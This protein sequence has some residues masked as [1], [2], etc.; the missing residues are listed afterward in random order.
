MTATGA[1]APPVPV[2]AA[3]RLVKHFPV[4]GGW[5]RRSGAQVHAVCDVSFALATGQTLALV[6]ES[7]CGKSTTA[8]LSA[9]LLTPDAGSVRFR[10]SD[11][12]AADRTE[13]RRYRQATAIV[14][15][16]SYA[17]LDPR[18]TVGKSIAEPLRV[19]GVA[20]GSRAD[21]VAE[22]L[23]QVGLSPAEAGR[24]PHQLSGGQRQRV[25]IARALSLAPELVVLDEP[26][27]ALDVSLRAGVTD[28]LG[29]L[30]ERTGVAYL[31]VSHDVSVVRHVAHRV[32]VM[33]LGRLVETGRLPDV[34]D[35]PAHPYTRALL[36]AVPLPDPVHERQRRRIVL[37]GEVPSAVRPPSGCRFR[38]RCWKAQAV[39]AEQTPSLA[40]VRPGHQVACHF[41]EED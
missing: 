1:A 23:R 13:Q 27:S 36:S 5:S 34:F 38:T 26:V 20:A 4:R 18:L 11:L 40:D 17:S 21:R 9:G 8:R 29:E 39:C 31:L 15:Q 19:H 24:H 37:T 14:F 25:G 33:Y 2:L 3:D 28:L 12:A 6:G 10:G 41:P 16:D 22:L 30:Q 7:G 32:A 35:Q